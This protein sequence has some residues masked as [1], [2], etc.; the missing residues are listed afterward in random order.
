MS[1][2]SKRRIIL[3]SFLETFFIG[4]PCCFNFALCVDHDFFWSRANFP[5]SMKELFE[6]SH[7]PRRMTW[8]AVSHSEQFSIQAYSF[9]LIRIWSFCKLIHFV[10]ASSLL[11]IGLHLYILLQ[12]IWDAITYPYWTCCPMNASTNRY[13]I[14]KN[15]WLSLPSTRTQLESHLLLTWFN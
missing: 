6:S 10:Y 9:F 2:T 13:K 14:S 12:G 8:P 5:V 4:L 1:S 3:F 7:H 15:I 11:T